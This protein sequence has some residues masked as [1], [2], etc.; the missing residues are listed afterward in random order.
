[1][2]ITAGTQVTWTNQDGATHNV[3]SNTGVF[4]S[5]DLS[6]GDTFEFTFDSLGTFPYH[7]SHHSGMNG[8][9]IVQ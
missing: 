7:C 1:L 8:T 3:I 2:T 4:S 9:V 6:G 5:G